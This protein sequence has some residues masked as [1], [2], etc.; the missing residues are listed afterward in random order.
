[1][2]TNS[3][4]LSSS[5]LPL[6]STI[7]SQLSEQVWS[8][9]GILQKQGGDIKSGQFV[10]GWLDALGQHEHWTALN[11]R[12]YWYRQWWA[13]INHLFVKRWFSP[14]EKQRFTNKAFDFYAHQLPQ[15]VQ[16]QASTLFRHFF[17]TLLN[18]CVTVGYLEEKGRRHI[19][20]E[21]LYKDDSILL[22]NMNRENLKQRGIVLRT[23]SIMHS[24]AEKKTVVFK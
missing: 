3:P 19:N 9:W 4:R 16:Q 21:N 17:S 22:V 8:Q 12:E 11:K 5:K 20:Q 6:F 13:K 24:Y 23:I 18:K 2:P 1:M 10:I 15:A 14:N 7:S